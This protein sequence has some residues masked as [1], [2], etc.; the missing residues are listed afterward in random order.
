MQAQQLALAPQSTVRR[1]VDGF[2]R[3]AKLERVLALACIL[4]P[5]ILILFDDLPIRSS[6]SDYY[7]MRWDQLFY[8]PLTAVSMLFVV[9]GIVKERRAYNTILGTMLA[10]VI[11]FNCD[12]FPRTH[13]L[14]ASVF[15][16]G[17]GAVILFYSS[18]KDYSFKAIMAAAIL[19]AVLAC[20]AF[21]LI[22]LFWLEWISLAMIAMHY[23]IESSY[24]VEEPWRLPRPLQRAPDAG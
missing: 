18:L 8:F 13:V 5:A 16:I 4:I 15:F 17:N 10:G 21:H 19:A 22:S 1:A 9:N 20:F 12:D 24:G 23:F 11:L 3:L 7:K 6:I 14:F 2:V